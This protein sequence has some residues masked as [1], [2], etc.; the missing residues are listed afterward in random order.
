MLAIQECF[1]K[2]ITIRMRHVLKLLFSTCEISCF[3]VKKMI[4]C[5]SKVSSW[6]RTF[7]VWSVLMKVI[8]LCVWIVMYIRRGLGSMNGMRERWILCLRKWCT[9]KYAWIDA[10]PNHKKELEPKTII[11]SLTRNECYDLC[12]MCL[13]FLTQKIGSLAWYFIIL[14]IFL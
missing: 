11:F 7:R 12:C 5:I 14:Y 9:Y 10:H 6:F 2:G 8:P 4:I 13:H 3:C 1:M